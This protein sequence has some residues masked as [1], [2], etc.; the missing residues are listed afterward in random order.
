MYTWNVMFNH[1]MNIKHEY[2]STFEKYTNQSFKDMCVKLS[3]D[4]F[5]ENTIITEYHHFTGNLVLIKYDMLGINT[6]LFTNPNSI[7]R[8]GRSLVINLTTEEIV[9]CPFR[10]FFNIGEIEETDMS[11]VQE[12]MK[13]ASLIEFS[14]KLDGSMLSFRWYNNTLVYSSSGNLDL[15]KAIQLELGIKLFNANVN[16][17]T[18]VS[19]MPEYTF[20]FEGIFE[21]DPH[22]VNYS[23]SS[24][25]L[26]GIRNV[27]TGKTMTYA[28]T[29]AIGKKYNIPTTTLEN[30][31]MEDIIKNKS[32]YKS[33]DKE[34]WVIHIITNDNQSFRY[35]FKCDD[36]VKLHK[37]LNALSSDNVVI[38]AIADNTYDDLIAQVPDSYRDRVNTTAEKIYEFLKI[39]KT[40]IERYYNM[41]KDAPSKKDFALAVNKYVPKDIVS[42]MFLKKSNKPYNLLRKFSNS[43][44]K[45]GIIDDFLN[46]YKPIYNKMERNDN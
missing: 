5:I 6:D 20:I 12:Q 35:K 36:Y 45:M 43:F 7:Y 38:Q 30:T 41:Y 22:V 14:N 9:L 18:M 25:N 32:K 19:A 16:Y 24:L 23:G 29:I 13:A 27:Y 10:K 40:L 21:E 2:E 33:S 11:I 31:N 44:I 15:N 3:Y 46:T 4:D 42:Y 34:G 37:I 17:Q 8:E 26:I 1:I 28:D 39:K